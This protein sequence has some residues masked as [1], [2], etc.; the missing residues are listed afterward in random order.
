MV[1][2]F[3]PVVDFLDVPVPVVV[4]GSGPIGFIPDQLGRVE[5]GALTGSFSACGWHTFWLSIYS[6]LE[7]DES[8]HDS[9]SEVPLSR[10]FNPAVTKTLIGLGQRC[11]HRRWSPS[12]F[13][14]DLG[15]R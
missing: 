14:K 13:G 10:S 2:V 7:A 5:D 3:T 9:V 4:W 15:D 1:V 8:L 6:L 11:S 12:Q